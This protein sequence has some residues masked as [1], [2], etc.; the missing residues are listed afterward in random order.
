MSFLRASDPASAMIGT[1]IAKRPKSMARP[2]VV[3]YQGRVAGQAGKGAAV[4][5]GGRAVGVED[6]AEAMRAAV[7]ASPAQ[8]PIC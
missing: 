3:L 7:V 4:V 6:F 8:V 1:I 2:S 5:A